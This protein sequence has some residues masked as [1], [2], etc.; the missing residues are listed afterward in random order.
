MLSEPIIVKVKP[1][2]A[3]IWQTFKS[4]KLQNAFGGYNL[5]ALNPS[6][7]N[8]NIIVIGKNVYNEYVADYDKS[9]FTNI[10]SIFSK[11]RG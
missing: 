9:V 10:D 6:K 2:I 3:P 8:V 11:V 4:L 5:S 7:G 1:L